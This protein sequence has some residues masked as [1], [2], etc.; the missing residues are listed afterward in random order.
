MTDLKERK[1]KWIEE[2]ANSVLLQTLGLVWD[3]TACKGD[4]AEED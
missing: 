2:E 3:F 1:V 4:G